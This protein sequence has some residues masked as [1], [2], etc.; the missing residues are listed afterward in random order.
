[1]SASSHRN[2][3]RALALAAGLT[4]VAPIAHAELEPV[5]ADSATSDPSLTESI[6]APRFDASRTA[7]RSGGEI[8]ALVPELSEHPY[9]LAPGPRAFMNRISF[10]PGYGRLGSESLFAFRL[11]YNPNAWLGYEAMLG[12]NPAQSVHAVI[13]SLS[14]IV[15]APLPGRFQPYGTGGYGMMIVF[16]GQS[17]NAD[18]VTK[19]ALTVGG[20]LELYLR[21][22]LALRG[23]MRYATVFGRDR[24]REGVVTYNYVQET[25]GL[26]F[27]RSIRP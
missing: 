5:A 11:A 8:E 27:Y 4:A 13:H 14:A 7:R 10:S 6:E 18:P 19:N 22:D 17:L 16:P 26:S 3:L 12:H 15:R 21:S 23:E 20:G 1:M 2:V 24:D 25:I 9:R